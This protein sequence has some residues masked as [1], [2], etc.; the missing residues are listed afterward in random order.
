MTIVTL[1][2]VAGGLFGLVASHVV[3]TQNQFRLQR[4]QV[5]ADKAESRYERLRLEKARLE[6]P[7]RIVAVAQQRLGMVPPATV[8]YLTPIAS[9]ATAGTPANAGSSR[10]AVAAPTADWSSVK[11]RLAQRP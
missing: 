3:L 2:V 4:L 8:R 10:V 9:I 1:I 5:S 7:E 6:A 11:Q